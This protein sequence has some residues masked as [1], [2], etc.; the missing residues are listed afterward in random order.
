MSGTAGCSSRQLS[1]RDTC[2][3][4][5]IRAVFT[6]DGHEQCNENSLVKGSEVHVWSLQPREI[7]RIV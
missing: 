1:R 7:K 3:H 5:V 4:A 2:K 6:A